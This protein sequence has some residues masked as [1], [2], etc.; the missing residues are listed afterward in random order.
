MD[1]LGVIEEPDFLYGRNK[2]GGALEILKVLVSRGTNSQ[3][4]GERRSGK[5]S[6]LKCLRSVFREEKSYLLVFVDAKEANLNKSNSSCY[7]LFISLL[8]FELSVRNYLQDS[9]RLNG[10]LVQQVESWEDAYSSL[11]SYPPI[12]LPG[13]LREIILFYS[14]YHSLSFVFLIDEIEHL[15][16]VAFEEPTAFMAIRN[17]AD[18]SYADRKPLTYVVAGTKSWEHLCTEVGSPELNNCGASIT[19]VGPI[20]YPSF[21]EMWVNYTLRSDE[22]FSE[23]YFRMSGGMPYFAKKVF[24]TVTAKNSQISHSILQSDFEIIFRNLSESEVTAV[25]YGLSGRKIA[26][27]TIFSSLVDRGILTSSGGVNGHLFC[28]YIKEKIAEIEA[29]KNK[30]ERNEMEV[31]V[32]KVF[33]LIAKINK[34]YSANKKE[35]AFELTNNENEHRRWLLGTETFNF[36]QAI[37]QILFERTGYKNRKF[38]R[39]PKIFGREHDF[40]RLVD[41]ARQEFG[42]H[43]TSASTYE[44]RE[45]QMSKAEMLTALTGQAIEPSSSI[46]PNIRRELIKRLSD[47]LESLDKFLTQNAQRTNIWNGIR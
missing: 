10:F 21:H 14:E 19:Y 20:D 30:S 23:E 12:K 25:R 31:L 32:E 8:L 45:H 13:L 33:L 24:E 17:L 26:S 46:H 7:K 37:Y 40:V 43:D 34:T 27:L 36:I 38:A 18:I 1:R 2:K 29:G 5:T 6:V 16:K 4:Q 42:G 39:L 3:I 9:N 41:C 47:Y 22:S 28:S 15:M 11:D 44:H 35:F